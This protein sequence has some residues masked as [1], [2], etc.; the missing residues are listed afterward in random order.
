MHD[1]RD[2]IAVHHPSAQINRNYIIAYMAY[3]ILTANTFTL[4]VVLQLQELFI[5]LHNPI[6]YKHF[7]L[8]VLLGYDET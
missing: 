6:V 5:P 3:K 4:S 2:F 7:T 1:Q 8:M